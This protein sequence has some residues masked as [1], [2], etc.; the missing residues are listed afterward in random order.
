MSRELVI[1]GTRIADDTDCYVIAEIGHNHQGDVEHCKRLFDAAARRRR[2]AR[3]SCRSG[4]TGRCSR[5]RPTTRRTTARTPSGRPT[6]RTARRSSS[7]ATS[8]SS[9]SST[10]RSSASR[11]SRPPSTCRAPTSSPSSTCRPTRSPPATCA[12]SRCCEHVARIGKPMIVSTGA[13][14]LDDVR[15]A[16]DAVMP[17]N[18]QLALL[19]CTA[20]Y[21][22]EYEQLD[23]RVIDTYRERVPGRGRRASPG[24]TAGSRCRPS[25]T[26]WARGSSRS[27]SPSTAR[28]G[29][30]TTRSRSSRSGCA[31]SSATSQRARMALGDG[32]KQFYETE[33]APGQK[34]GKK[35]VAARDLPA[36]HVLTATTS[37]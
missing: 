20:A 27:T 14:T 24:T 22:P 36:G 21:P 3:S 33:V 4:T 25:P 15:R 17:I 29:A 32:T 35:L 2:L 19:Q 26:P 18:P 8:T 7:A 30:P 34:M 37:P 5:G 12:A 10:R 6:A 13:A 16:Y 28:C 11:S 23:L 9:C 1:D 31:S